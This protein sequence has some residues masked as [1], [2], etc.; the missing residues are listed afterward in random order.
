MLYRFLEDDIDSVKLKALE[1]IP[2]LAGRIE[3][4]ER[5]IKLL[6]YPLNMD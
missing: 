1:Q 6:E 3:Q 2:F 4:S 5:D